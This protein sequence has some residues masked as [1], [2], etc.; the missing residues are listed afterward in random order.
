MDK[1]YTDDIAKQL[2]SDYKAAIATHNASGNLLSSL[3]ANV[4]FDDAKYEIVIEGP[5]YGIFLENGTRPHFPPVDKILEW[6]RIK[7]VLPRAGANGKLPTENQLAFLIARKI[8]QVG[9]EGTHTFD[10]VIEQKNYVERLALAIAQ[11]LTK[12]FDEEHIKDLV[13][14]KTK[15]N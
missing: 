2:L 5:E 13:A 10:K 3:T 9:T 15:R 6:V 12:E 8:S 1:S 4:N 14:P 11:E 7:P